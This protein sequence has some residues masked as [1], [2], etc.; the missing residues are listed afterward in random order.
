M[1]SVSTDVGGVDVRPA[2]RGFPRLSLGTGLCVLVLAV[3]GFVVLYPLWLILYQSFDVSRPGEAAR[4]GLDGWYAIFNERGLRTAVNNT[5]LLSISRQLIALPI[6]IGIAWLIARTDLPGRNWFEFGF[7]LSFFLPTLTVTL[8][9][10][11][12]LDPDYGLFNQL[13]KPLGLHFNIY[14]FWGIV[15]THLVAHN[16]SVMVMLLTPAFRNMNASFEEASRVAGASTLSTIWRIFVPVMMPAILAVELIVLMRSLESFEVEQ[17]LGP[18][19]SL[20]V[21]ST[22]IYSTFYQQ[23]PRFD[24]ASA[25][26]VLLVLCMLVLIVLQQ[27]F[28]GNRKYTTVTGQFQGQVFRLGAARVPA[29]A[30]MGFVMFLIMGVPFVFATMGTFMKLFGYFTADPWTLQH[31]QTAFKEPLLLRSLQNTLIL[32]TSTA[33]VSVILNSLIAYIVVRTRFFGRHTLNFI[34][35]LPFTV[36]GILLSLGLLAMFLTPAF[37]PMYGSLYVLIIAGVVSGMPLAVQITK[38]NLMQLGPELEEASYITGGSWWHTYRHVVLPL[39][40]PTLVVVGLIAFIGAARNVAQVAL[41]SNAQNRPLSMLQL[42]YMAEGKFEV[43]AVVA[44][45]I[46]FLT[47]GLALAA[48]AFGYRA[49]A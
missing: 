44:C 38:S 15:W 31:W 33:L 22:W 47:V 21:M 32:A 49:S 24:A 2:G 43:A 9:W 16:I 3:V 20:Q 48:R 35:W 6:A 39:L 27:R 30:F 41:L 13:I 40:R 10:I 5:L 46:L 12:V 14:S 42:D 18:P 36:P 25:L 1:A 17:I 45:V 34:T 7:W 19:I 4:F 23:T 28:L 37:R 26:A 11:L 8:S 29:L